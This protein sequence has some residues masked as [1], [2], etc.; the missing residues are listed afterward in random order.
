MFGISRQAYYQ[1]LKIKEKEVFSSEI[2]LQKVS[3][4]RE[5]HPKMGTRKLFIKLR[6]FIY[7]NNIKIG[8]DAFFD[9]L[10]NNNLLIRKRQRRIRTTY[11]N[12]WLRKYSNL[13]KDYVP[14]KANQ[15]YVSDITYWR[16][17]TGFIYIS[18][19]T[20]A[21]SRKIVGHYVSETLAADGS[22][23]ALKM[24]FKNNKIDDNTIHHSDRGV[25]YC[26]AEYITI[27]N[28]SYCKISMTES[29]DPKDNAIAERING[30]IKNEY[31]YNYKIYNI[32]EAKELLEAVVKLYNKERP[33]MS[34]GN[35][36]PEEIHKNA[37]IKFK[38]KWKSY[39]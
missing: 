28:K 8:R 27:L 17:E 33:H 12:H 19:I 6:E 20:D 15:L 23:Q 16:I 18:L 9:L 25:Q 38:R 2:L 34:I 22:I 7:D 29:G 35:Y 26:C 3:E 39:Y 36:T 13:I 24:A 10:S 31:L 11:S 21:Y 32:K 5:K 37:E 4:I 14:T 1:S 30:I